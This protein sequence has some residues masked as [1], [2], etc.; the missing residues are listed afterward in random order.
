[1]YCQTKNT[2]NNI[3]KGGDLTFGEF[4]KEN[5]ETWLPCPYLSRSD[6]DDSYFVS[7]IGMDVI[8][9]LHGSS[10]CLPNREEKHKQHCTEQVY[11]NK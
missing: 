3:Y 8:Q 11:T 6:I 2:N 1:M 10:R 7:L 4:L 9:H 5:A